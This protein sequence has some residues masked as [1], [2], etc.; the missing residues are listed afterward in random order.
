[1]S[2]ALGL[3]LVM[4]IAP[5]CT[6]VK[7][8]GPASQRVSSP[9]PISVELR[10]PKGRT[11]KFDLFERH[12]FKRRWLY[13]NS[14][15][16]GVEGEGWM[17]RQA[18]Q[19]EIARKHFDRAQAA[20]LLPDCR[21][22]QSDGGFETWILLDSVEPNALVGSAERAGYTDLA[23]P[24][25]I[26]EI[27]MWHDQGIDRLVLHEVVHLWCGSAA[28]TQSARGRWM[29]EGVAD[30]VAFATLGAAPQQ[31]IT[32][33]FAKPCA[34]TSY[35][36]SFLWVLAK[37]LGEARDFSRILAQLHLG[38]RKDFG[39]Q[40]SDIHGSL[41]PLPAAG[42][43]AADRLVA[44]GQVVSRCSGACVPIWVEPWGIQVHPPQTGEPQRFF[45][46]NGF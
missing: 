24:G 8:R 40:V 14:V 20:G 33:Y 37:F 16:D 42:C 44:H 39:R 43:P 26:V 13:S 2:R 34:P 31:A 11:A 41:S 3:L 29:E 4:F 25:P 32:E 45:V 21:P 6:L 19:M 17:E 35:G 36:S 38:E 27:R 15:L 12:D 5:A 9:V 30:W 18:R 22:K 10:L 1:M 46:W 7:G 23:N 28:E